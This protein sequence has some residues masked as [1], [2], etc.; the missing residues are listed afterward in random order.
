AT[1]VG[2]L[3]TFLRSILEGRPAPLETFQAEWT[4]NAMAKGIDYGYSLWRIRPGGLF[5]LL[6]N[7][8]EMLGIS[9]ST[10]SFLYWVPEYDA[11]IAGSFNQTGYREK[12]V[13]FLIKV[14]R[15]LNQAAAGT[16]T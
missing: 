2:D 6:K 10:G 7:Y 11:V 13:A 5:F 3:R 15:V 12:H 14:L 8:P 16:E 4:E 1:T 9:G